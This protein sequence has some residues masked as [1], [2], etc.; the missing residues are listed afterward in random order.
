MAVQHEPNRNLIAH[1]RGRGS[2][3]GCQSTMAPQYVGPE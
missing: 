1:S 3:C 2:V